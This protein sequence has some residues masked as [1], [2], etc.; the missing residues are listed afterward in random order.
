MVFKMLWNE[1]DDSDVYGV[2]FF[3][4][5]AMKFSGGIEMEQWLK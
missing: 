3:F 5:R 2:P 1:Q 4:N